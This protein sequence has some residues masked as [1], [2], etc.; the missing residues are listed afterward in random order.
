MRTG[1][2]SAPNRPI[3]FESE[4]LTSVEDT[5]GP[6]MPLAA[7]APPK[8]IQTRLGHSSITTTM[9]LFGHVLPGLDEQI[10]AH[11]EAAHQ[12]ADSSSA[13][14]LLHNRAK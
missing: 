7:G 13:A 5:A 4:F 14:H 9:N 10:A 3:H 1:M 8:L 6:V 2:T 11:L 12:T